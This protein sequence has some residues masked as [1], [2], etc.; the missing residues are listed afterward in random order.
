MHFIEDLYNAVTLEVLKLALLKITFNHN[1]SPARR[2]VS[3]ATF[4]GDDEP[5][6]KILMEAKPKGMVIYLSFPG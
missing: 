3:I 1:R 2:K 4:F 5:M 6:R